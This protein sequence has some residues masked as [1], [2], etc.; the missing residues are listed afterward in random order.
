MAQIVDT[1]FKSQQF[2]D[3]KSNCLKERQ[4]FVDPEFTSVIALGDGDTIESEPEKKP[5]NNSEEQCKDKTS[6]I[7][8]STSSSSPVRRVKR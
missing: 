8:E 1:Y 3:I 4:L 2:H 7:E 5:H 6:E